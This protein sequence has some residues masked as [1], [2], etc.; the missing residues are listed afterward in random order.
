M[1]EKIYSIDDLKT[2]L[3]PLFISYDIDKA[4]LFGSYGKGQANEKSDVDLLVSSNLKG[5]KFV[6]FLED[7]TNAI[8]K[9]VDLFDVSHVNSGSEIEKE[10]QKTGVVLYEK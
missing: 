8:D 2:M 7:V 3:Y 10:I 1:S 5:L 9:Q 6:G 4:I